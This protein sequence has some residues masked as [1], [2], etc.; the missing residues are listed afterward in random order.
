[1]RVRKSR[2]AVVSLQWFAGVGRSTGDWSVL[3]V[4]YK[5]TGELG[6]LC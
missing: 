1:M 4:L 3:L 6:A 2:A 5:Y